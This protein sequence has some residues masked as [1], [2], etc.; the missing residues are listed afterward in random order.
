[1]SI[2][3]SHSTSDVDT[4]PG[5][6]R[7]ESWKEIAAYLNRSVRTLHRWEK[8]EGLP[9]H[10]Q[11]HKELGSVFAYKSE[12]EAWSRNRSVRTEVRANNREPGSPY[13]SR[14]VVTI[15]L[16]GA[17]EPPRVCRRAVNVSSTF[18]SSVLPQSAFEESHAGARRPSREA[19]C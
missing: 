16:S 14:L 12:L 10:R 3:P 8:E 18:V 9:V 17:V 11:L 13:R 4:S 15:A 1:M 19:R 5:G 2:P 6:E 7:L